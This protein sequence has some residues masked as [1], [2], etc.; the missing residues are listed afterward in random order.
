MPARL[1]SILALGLTVATL[2]GEEPAKPEAVEMF[3]RLIQRIPAETDAHDV[4]L[5]IGKEFTY[6]FNARNGVQWAPFW[7]S[8]RLYCIHH[9]K[10]AKPTIAVYQIIEPNLESGPFSAIGQKAYHQ[11]DSL[12]KERGSARVFDLYAAIDHGVHFEPDKLNYKKVYPLE[13]KAASSP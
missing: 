3:E 5:F 12:S 8:G 13:S 1:F 4:H 7:I 2:S 11:F 9:V 10:S 6:V